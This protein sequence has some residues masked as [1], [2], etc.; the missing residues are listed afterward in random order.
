MASEGDKGSGGVRGLKGSNFG[1]EAV[2]WGR[3]VSG[4]FVA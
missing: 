3:E 2:G 1:C 4:A